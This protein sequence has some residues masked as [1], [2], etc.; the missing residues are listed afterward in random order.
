M[1]ETR[2]RKNDFQGISRNV[3]GVDIVSM[4]FNYNQGQSVSVNTES[5]SPG[6]RV[7]TITS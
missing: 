4:K 2:K 6:S 1:N 5:T 3:D 7:I